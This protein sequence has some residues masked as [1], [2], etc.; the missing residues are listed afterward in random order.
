MTV[1]NINYNVY[2]EKST[3]YENKYNNYITY[4]SSWGAGNSNVDLASGYLTYKKINLNEKIDNSI[5]PFGIAG[6]C[7]I[8]VHNTIIWN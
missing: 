4:N 6:H 8:F 7:D 1:K 5:C 2:G 3:W